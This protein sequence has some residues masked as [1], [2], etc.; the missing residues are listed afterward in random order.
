MPSLVTV[1]TGN[2][3]TDPFL[4]IAALDGY[5]EIRGSFNIQAMNSRSSYETS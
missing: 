3:S 5:Y 1:Y 2:P 4:S